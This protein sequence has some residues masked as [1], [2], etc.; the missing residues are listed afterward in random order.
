ME[1]ISVKDKLPDHKEIVLCIGDGHRA[2]MAEYQQGYKRHQGMFARYV[3]QVPEDR[4]LLIYYNKVTHWMPL[5]NPP[6][7]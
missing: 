1:W 5:P 3:D 2:S 4:I 7:Q 6:Q